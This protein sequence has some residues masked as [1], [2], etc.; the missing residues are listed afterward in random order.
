MSV[1]ARVWLFTAIVQSAMLCLAFE[2]GRRA[3][4]H[5]ANARDAEGRAVAAAELAWSEVESFYGNRDVGTGRA[6]GGRCAALV[7]VSTVGD[8]SDVVECG[9]AGP[10]PF[11]SGE[12]SPWRIIGERCGLDDAGSR[13]GDD[14]SD[15]P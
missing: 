12:G 5:A 3:M 14:R 7:D 9:S 10:C 1:N 2:A 15:T 6:F 4:R 13:R 11:L 8:R